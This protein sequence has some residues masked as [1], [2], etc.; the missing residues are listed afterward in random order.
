MKY[1]YVYMMTNRTRTL[2]TGITN[3]LERRVLEH[4]HKLLP[5]FT[6]QYN[7]TR[8]VYFEVF[9]DVRLAIQREKQIKGWLRSK[10]VSE[11][12]KAGVARTCV[13]QRPAASPLH[14]RRN[15]GLQSSV[16]RSRLVTYKQVDEMTTYGDA[17]SRSADGVRAGIPR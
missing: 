14:G 3:N 7:L 12:T 16:P 5:E 2:Y 1:Y 6:N 11:K 8:L 15:R 9:G 13:D 4:K 17:D 10:K